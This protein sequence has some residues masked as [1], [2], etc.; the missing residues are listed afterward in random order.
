MDLPFKI[1]QY[2]NQKEYDNKVKTIKK[3]KN[4]NGNEIR[5]ILIQHIKSTELLFNT[6]K[7]VRG[8]NENPFDLIVGCEK[9]LNLVGFEIKG[10][11]D[12]FSRLKTQ[13]QGYLWVFDKVYL[14]LH[15][16]KLPEW[17]PYNIGIIRV[18]ENKEVFVEKYG[19]L[20]NPLDISTEYEW[21]SL[22]RCN[23][24]GVTSKRTRQVLELIG[25]IRRNIL[26]NRF[27]SVQNGYNTRNFEKFY[28]FTDIQKSVII[29]FD[30]PYH[31]KLLS[32]DLTLLEK[33]LENLKQAIMIGQ[34]GIKDF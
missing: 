4:L 6:E 26:F 7:N 24:L 19:Y 31:I 30:V 15:K 21:D 20:D 17:L 8:L 5:E 1:I 25:G 9:D 3:E 28:P 22:F 27:F 32:T 11:T 29:G 10:D 16:K 2:D 13:L 18:F 33:R 34:K 14:V 23:G 12:N